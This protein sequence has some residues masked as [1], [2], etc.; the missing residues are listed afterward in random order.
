MYPGQDWDT[1]KFST[2]ETNDVSDE[3][4]GGPD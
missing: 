4:R 3:R 1:C 2:F